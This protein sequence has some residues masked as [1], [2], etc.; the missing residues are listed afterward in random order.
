MVFNRQS[1]KMGAIQRA[2]ARAA[3]RGSEDRQVMNQH[4][5][6][7]FDDFVVDPETWRLTQGGQEIHLKPVVLKL[8]IYL[9]ANRGRLV[10]RQELMDTVWGDTVIS[11]SAL[12]KAAARLRKALGDDS[13]THR[14][15]E[16]VRSQGY[17]FVA[18]VEETECADAASPPPGKARAAGLRRNVLTGAAAVLAVT[19]VALLWTGWPRDDASQM[20]EIRSLAVLPLNNLTGDPEQ[21]YYVDGLH[22]LLITEVSKLPGVRV[23]SRQSTKRYRD[24]QLS[25]A[26]IARELG[27]DALVEGSLLQ[28]GGEIEVTVQLIHGPSDAHLWAERYTRETPYVFSLI[29]DMAKSIGAAIGARMVSPGIEGANHEPI[30]PVDPRA[31]DAYSLGL[32][33]MD[34]FTPGELRLAI[35]QFEKAVAI[36]PDFALA[37]GQLGAAESM[38]GLYGFVRPQESK[39]KLRAAV[40]KAVEADDQLF[41]GHSGLAWVQ[42]W[43]GDFDGACDSFAGALRLNPSAPYAIHGDSDCLMFEGRMDESI[44]RTRELLLVSPF[45]AM[46][47]SPLPNHLYVARRYDEA[48]AAATDMQARVPQF[49]MHWFLAKV[50]WQQGRL[51]KALEEERLEFGRRGDTV[52]LAALEEGLETGGPIGAMRAMAKAMVARANESFVDPFDIGETLARAGVVGEALYWLERAVEYG[53]YELNYIAFLPHLDVLRDDPRFQVLLE[54]V[55]GHKAQDIRRVANALRTQAQ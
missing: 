6:Y 43:T 38:L 24:S 53:S 17:R 28:K 52:L 21:A 25:T 33:H 22:D 14:Y 2:P 34:R 35:E 3:V 20:E 27:V 15:L 40:L 26:D 23:T 16:T 41:I 32:A 10:T 51:D 45:S 49:S 29:S 54:R 4:P 46:H 37:W 19:L 13:A 47:S 9:I 48:I 42:W 12:T 55:Y 36:E 44:A 50:Y 5:V 39:E 11:E 31:I 30:G 18:D 7:C 1:R 8:L